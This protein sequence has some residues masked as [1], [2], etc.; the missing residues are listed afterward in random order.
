MSRLIPVVGPVALLIALWIVGKLCR[1][2][3]VLSALLAD[4]LSDVPLGESEIAAYED[5]S[6]HVC[7]EQTCDRE[8][9]EP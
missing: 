1:D 3:G 6:R 2:E 4:D 7:T 5:H 9:S 8:R